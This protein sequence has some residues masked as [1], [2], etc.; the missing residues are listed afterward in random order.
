MQTRRPN[1]AHVGAAVVWIIEC[2]QRVLEQAA[3]DGA[4]VEQDQQRVQRRHVRVGAQIELEPV[5]QIRVQELL[6]DDRRIRRGE[7]R[8]A[9]HTRAGTAAHQTLQRAKLASTQELHALARQ[10]V[11]VL[12]HPHHIWTIGLLRE[13][14]LT[15]LQLVQRVRLGVEVRQAQPRHHGLRL[16]GLVVVG[17][18]LVHQ[19]LVVQVHHILEVG[20]HVQE[21][22][23]V[24]HAL[25]AQL[26]ALA[27]DLVEHVPERNLAAVTVLAGVVPHLLPVVFLEVVHDRHAAAADLPVRGEAQRAVQRRQRLRRRRHHHTSTLRTLRLHDAL[28]LRIRPRHRPRL[29]LQRVPRVQTLGRLR[30]VAHLAVLAAQHPAQVQTMVLALSRRVT[31]RVGGHG[32]RRGGR[33][34][35]GRRGRRRWPAP[36]VALRVIAPQVALARPR[37][38]IRQR[39][40]PRIRLCGLLPRVGAPQALLVS[41]MR[42]ALSARVHSR[43]RRPGTAVPRIQAVRICTRHS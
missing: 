16:A 19:H 7:R 14:S 27:V 30:D 25:P 37:P 1:V 10:Q 41:S 21:R 32:R 11:G 29:Q 5:H 33:G 20:R 34:R 23:V 6:H 36:P 40:P 3:P 22:V 13:E 38:V 12:L 17:Q 35:R 43:R 2:A 8:V 39:A 4:L 26:N 18:P 31:I 42:R 9:L 24:V 15:L 28:Q